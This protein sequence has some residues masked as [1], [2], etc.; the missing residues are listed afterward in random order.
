MCQTL[1]QAYS[2]WKCIDPIFCVLG[3]KIGGYSSLQLCACSRSLGTS[4]ELLTATVGPRASCGIFGPSHWKSITGVKN[5]SKIWERVTGFWLPPPNKSFLTF[6]A[7]NV[8]A[9][10]H[11]NRTRIATVYMSADRQTDRQKDA[12][13]FIICPLPCYAIAKGQID[14]YISAYSG[15]GVPIVFNTFSVDRTLFHSKVIHRQV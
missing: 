14:S 11:Q 8:C 5:W 13:D 1:S 2:H 15:C 9:K 3:G 10:F 7:P 6:R 4:F 12:S